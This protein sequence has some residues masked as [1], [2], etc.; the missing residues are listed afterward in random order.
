MHETVQK[1]SK[2][3][4]ALPLRL[5]PFNSIKHR[6][7][8]DVSQFEL[9]CSE[10]IYQEGQACLQAPILNPRLLIIIRAVKSSSLSV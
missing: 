9:H 7:A 10:I 5:L 3:E 4:L 8:R 6:L 2:Y 1:Y